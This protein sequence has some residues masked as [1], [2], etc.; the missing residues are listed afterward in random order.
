MSFNKHN[1]ICTAIKEYMSDYRIATM[2]S[3]E[4]SA[5]I[6]IAF[7]IFNGVFALLYHSVWHLSVF[8]YYAI[9]LGIRGYIIFSI[10]TKQSQKK[11]YIRT[12]IFLLIM[13]IS[14]VFPFAVMVN[15][16][17]EYNYGLIPA[18]AIAAYTTYRITMAS[19][20]LRKSRKIETLLIKELR[21]INFVDSLMAI[22][23]LQNT[24]IMAN[25]GMTEEMKTLCSWS[26]GGVFL[27][28]LFVII[29]SF[30]LVKKHR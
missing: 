3:S 21:T 27:L 22:T 2:I 10:K 9:L 8:C 15:G 24:M 6:N 4:L 5:C 18:I 7:V 23:S 26:N 20:H 30:C 16:E 25:G 28:L 19:I 29:Y 11:V 12:H 14:M 17:R 1:R 13:S